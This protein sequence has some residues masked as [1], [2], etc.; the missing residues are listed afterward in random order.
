MDKDGK[1]AVGKEDMK[2][3]LEEIDIRITDQELDKIFETCDENGTGFIEYQEFIR[4]ACDIKL[5]LSDSN[6]K[7]V[8]H[9]ICGDKNLMSGEDIKKF[10]FHDAKINDQALKEYFDSFGM[11][12]ENSID[13][14]D[15][16]RMIKKNKKYTP[17]K[18]KKRPSK[19]EFT[20]PVIDEAEK[21]EEQESEDDIKNEND[22]DNE[23]ENEIKDDNDKINEK[24]NN[25]NSEHET[26]ASN[27]VKA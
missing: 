25:G 12:Y 8:F 24:L 6:L 3:T 10:I 9:A 1:N 14:D 16:C 23:K 26:T 5:L 17:K 15:F 2:Q 27:G 20:G 7:N 11:K 13:F 18:K 21:E 22:G 4:N 19:Y